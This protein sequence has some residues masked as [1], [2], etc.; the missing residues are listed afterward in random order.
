MRLFQAFTNIILL[1]SLS[2]W[3]V[4]CGGGGNELYVVKPSW[5]DGVLI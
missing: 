5:T 3:L 4:A 2:V 1:T